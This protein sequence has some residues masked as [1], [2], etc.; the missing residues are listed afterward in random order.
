MAIVIY[1]TCDKSTNG[2]SMVNVN[3]STSD[4]SVQRI[5]QS[6]SLISTLELCARLVL[7]CRILSMS[8]AVFKCVGN[9]GIPHPRLGAGI[10]VTMFL[11]SLYSKGKS[12]S[13]ESTAA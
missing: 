1:F 7:K 12:K 8:S 4:K 3:Y 2:Y 9:G 5:K 10:A 13:A 6:A 11:N